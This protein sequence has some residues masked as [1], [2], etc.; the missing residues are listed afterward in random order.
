M[1]NH[2]DPELRIAPSLQGKL[3]TAQTVLFDWAEAHVF[4]WPEILWSGDDR[5]CCHA[6]GLECFANRCGGSCSSRVRRGKR[7]RRWCF[8]SSFDS[9]W[10]ARSVDRSS[11]WLLRWPLLSSYSEFSKIVVV[12]EL[13]DSLPSWLLLY[14]VSGC[15]WTVRS[16]WQL[17]HHFRRYSFA[18]QGSDSVHRVLPGVDHIV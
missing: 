15:G 12:L 2:S 8:R 16:T 4:E 1:F 9:W 10:L 18:D 13:V 11:C 17:H 5:D 14:Q 6:T 3:V 7:E